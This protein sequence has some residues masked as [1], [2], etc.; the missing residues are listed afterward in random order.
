LLTPAGLTGALDGHA[1]QALADAGSR[2]DRDNFRYA[3]A[4]AYFKDIRSCV[5]QFLRAALSESTT[6]LFP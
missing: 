6:T 1:V 5:R 3:L 4:V 2:I